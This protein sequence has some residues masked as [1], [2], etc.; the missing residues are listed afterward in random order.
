MQA[1]SGRVVSLRAKR[2]DLNL[3]HAAMWYAVPRR[4]PMATGA[5]VYGE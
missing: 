2:D 3:T 5:L 1:L 4:H